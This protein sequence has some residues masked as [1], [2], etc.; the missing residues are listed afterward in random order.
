MGLD[1]LAGYALYA[2][3]RT[4]TN[5]DQY[6]TRPQLAGLGHGER[7]AT[8]TVH[9]ALRTVLDGTVLCDRCRTDA[10]CDDGSRGGA[11][12][13]GDEIDPRL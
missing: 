9:D 2:H 3:G 10:L 4:P 7:R 11:L 6:R 8:R 1:E 5:N 12:W 13:T